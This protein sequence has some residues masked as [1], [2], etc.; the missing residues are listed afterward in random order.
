MLPELSQPCEST[1]V[2]ATAIDG[3]RMGLLAGFAPRGG[4]AGVQPAASW[5]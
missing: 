4:A 1:E 5:L 2:G 3:V